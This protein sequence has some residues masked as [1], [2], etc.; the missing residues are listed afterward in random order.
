M[1]TRLDQ[2][3]Y[4]VSKMFLKAIKNTL[5]LASIVIH[6]VFYVLQLVLRAFP[7]HLYRV[8]GNTPPAHPC[9]LIQ[10]VFCRQIIFI[11]Q[12]IEVLEHL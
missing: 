2:L 1:R 4:D 8:P 12:G 10:V 7:D 11:D 9:G 3:R 6:H 5:L